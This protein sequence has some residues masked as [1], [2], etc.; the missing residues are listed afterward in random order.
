MSME[1]IPAPAPVNPGSAPQ[2]AAAGEPSYSVWRQV[3]RR[4]RKHRLAVA[5]LVVFLALVL[6]SAAA[7]VLAPYNPNANDYSVKLQPPTR[8]HLFGTDDFGRDILSRIIWGGQRSLSVGIV[9]VG[10]GLSAG[11]IIGAVAGYA[12]GWV[13]NLLM[14][15]MDILLAFP[16]I[17]LAIAIMS[18]LG[19]GLG[20]AM[21]AIGIVAIPHY[22]RIVR[23]SVLTIRENDYVV[24]AQASGA[25]HS[26]IL[27]RHVMPNAMAPIIVR[28]TL[29]TSEAIL[30]AAALGFL[31]LGVQPPYAEWGAMLAGVQEYI[32]VAPHVTAF[33]GLMITLTVLA[34]N[35]F[36]DGLRDALDPRLKT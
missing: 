23:A 5:G 31:G 12:G 8:A 1:P 16:S 2:P 33:P 13:D 19:R 9:A 24:A 26:R 11:L 18:I 22:A 10:I 32:R 34:L 27:W 28:A 25:S 20:K 21:I 35:L 7:P 30:E 29:G 14:R 4:L 36:G 15:A 3:W 17:L 6:I